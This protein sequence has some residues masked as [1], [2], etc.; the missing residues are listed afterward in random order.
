MSQRQVMIDPHTSLIMVGCGSGGCGRG[1][2]GGHGGGRGQGCG[3][4]GLTNAK[5][6]KL[7]C[8]WQGSSQ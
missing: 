1:P 7:H 8:S 6:D 4:S 5:K 2:D 3:Q